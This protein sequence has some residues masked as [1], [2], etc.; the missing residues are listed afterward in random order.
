MPTPTYDLIASNV[1]GTATSSVSFT[2]I[3]GSYRDLIIVV[4]GLGNGGEINADLRFNSDSGNN[5][6]FVRMRGSGTAASSSTGTSKTVITTELGF[7]NTEQRNHQIM[8][9]MDYSATNKHKTVLISENSN[10]VYGVI[11]AAARWANT[12]AITSV[13]VRSTTNSFDT[14]TSFYLYGIVS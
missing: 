1:L 11:S 9:I 14:G 6:S 10:G 5:Y 12:S 4:N 2:S 3:S 7:S 13:E 8:Q